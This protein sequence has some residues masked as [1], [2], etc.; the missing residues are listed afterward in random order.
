M[1]YIVNILKEKY[2]SDIKTA[3]EL[4]YKDK[5]VD[6]Y[7]INA[8]YEKNNLKD[9]NWFK[10][11]KIKFN[12]N[13]VFLNPSFYC[14]ANKNLL[15]LYQH[16][17][18]AMGSIK[19]DAWIISEV[20]N[21]LWI[22]GV[23]SSKKKIKQIIKDGSYYKD[24]KDII[25]RNYLEAINFISTTNEISERT[26]FTLYTILSKDVDMGNEKLDSYPYRKEDVKIG[27][28]G[29]TGLHPSSVKEHMDLLIEFI[30]MVTDRNNY[31][32]SLLAPIIIHYIFEIIHPY[33]DMNGRM[34]RLLIL[35]M[36]RKMGMIPIN[37]Y[38]SESI[39]K[40]KVELYYDAFKKSS[41][42]NFKNDV[43]YFTSSIMTAVIANN[44][45]VVI[46]NEFKKKV[47]N[48]YKSTLNDTEMDI[49]S[50]LASKDNDK[51]YLKEEFVL[52]V[53]DI[54]PGQLSKMFSKLI[55]FGVIKETNTK[56]KKY[57]LNWNKEIYK[58]IDKLTY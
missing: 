48:K 13:N 15:S 16:S 56:P 4:I 55:E 17:N 21:S 33:Y 8:S 12:D 47:E 18:I 9:K 29:V 58:I 26:I 52:G 37:R 7:D 3:K 53:D 54:N 20:T 14:D 28:D 31:Q 39:N 32:D 36:S 50:A 43:T 25:T 5:V 23:K 38:I 45:S 41:I 46:A 49:V 11:E 34:G 22:E 27:D 35:W 42:N 51:F 44:I 30:N 6:V 10:L 40:F 2:L 57:S 19:D 1:S 24:N